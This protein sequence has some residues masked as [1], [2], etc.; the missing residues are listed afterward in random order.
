DKAV[1]TARDLV[2]KQTFRN[3][4]VSADGTWLL[5]ECQGSALYQV[6]IDL[7]D[8]AAP[9]GR[10][11]CPSHK[12]PCKH[13]L[14]L[15]LAYLDAPG[16]FTPREPSPALL[17][18]REKQAERVPKPEAAGPKP[19]KANLAAQAKKVAAQREGLDLLERLLL[20]LVAGGPWASPSGL[21]RLERQAN[22]MND[23]YLPG[24]RAMLRRLVLLDVG[25]ELPDDV[26]N[27]LASDLIGQ[28]WATVQKGRASLDGKLAGDEAEAVVE[29][30]LGHSWKLDE[31]RA[32]GST[33][34]DLS[35]LELAYERVDDLARE[36]RVETSHLIERNDGTI[37]RAI[38]YRPFKGLA[39]IAEQP[40]YAEALTVAEAAVYP[41]FLNRRIRWE[42]G[43]EQSTP[44]TPDHLRAACAAAAPALEPVLAAFRQQLK[45]PLA[46]REAV[47][48]VRYARV[49][50]VG[51]RVVL[52]D[53][54]GARLEAADLPDVAG[55]VANLVRAAGMIAQPAVLARLHVVPVA[56]T[57]V[58]QP[59]AALSADVHLRLGL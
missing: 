16:S 15:M 52:E 40:S 7:A 49:G 22:Q 27:A 38:T 12:F 42:K 54:P 57:I 44:R 10:C 21:A 48:L 32:K 26:R 29:D 23:A 20:D 58:A 3:P 33:R 17:A 4:G 13:A 9:V 31:L 47:V 1:K 45:N 8:A 28:I 41:G 6:S 59:L 37:Y 30:L 43:A 55:N 18:K 25:H 46:P 39:R 51:D 50:R 5:A 35:L 24:A 11:T 36:E 19:K 14:G 53:D 56:N 2:R 34:R